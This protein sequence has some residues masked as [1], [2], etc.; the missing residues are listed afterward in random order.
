MNLIPFRS[1]VDD[2][3]TQTIG[4]KEFPTRA[5]LIA[6][7]GYSDAFL[8]ESFLLMYATSFYTLDKVG[9]HAPAHYYDAAHVA[10]LRYGE[11]GVRFSAKDI[12]ESEHHDMP[13]DIGR[14]LAKS[15]QRYA[16][17]AAL[18]VTDVINDLLAPSTGINFNRALPL[19]TNSGEMIFNPVEESF[20]P[21][22]IPNRDIVTRGSLVSKLDDAYAG[23]HITGRRVNI[24][25][26]DLIKRWQYIQLIVKDHKY[27]SAEE[28][29]YIRDTLNRFIDATAKRK[30]NGEILE[31]RVIDRAVSTE[32]N[33]VKHII[34]DEQLLTFPRKLVVGKQSPTI[35]DA[36]LTLYSTYIQKL[37]DAAVEAGRTMITQGSHETNDEYL[38]EPKIK[39][40]DQRDVL[41]RMGPK[42]ENKYSIATKDMVILEKGP[43]AVTSMANAGI[44]YETLWSSLKYL[45]DVLTDEIRFQMG[46]AESRMRRQ[47]SNRD[48]LDNFTHISQ[49][50]SQLN[51]PS[52]IEPAVRSE[53][54][55]LS[56]LSLASLRSV[57]NL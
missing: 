55:L 11:S 25:Y 48:E 36:K 50:L 17:A 19:L 9:K 45:N 4:R 8:P 56:R 3:V 52:E 27:L 21:Q 26:Q 32:Y 43:H 28:A 37:F 12:A 44:P 30:K 46:D 51:F 54:G 15:D 53:K 39:C 22:L 49:L 57:F 14:L 10:N 29:E 20:E 47:T 24:F 41:T 1:T 31:P 13:E 16:Y 2:I 6:Q 23:F 18:V 42:P 33:R 5:Q 34:K 40:L 7:A 38:R 35:L